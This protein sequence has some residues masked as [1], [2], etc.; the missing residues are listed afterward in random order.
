[1]AHGERR[2]T[3]ELDDSDDDD[4]EA[5]TDEQKKRMNENRMKALGN[6]V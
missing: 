3:R 6:E 5:L 2:V 1:M 4:E